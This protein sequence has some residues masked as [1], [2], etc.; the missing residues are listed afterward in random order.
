MVCSI[1][2]SLHN[3]RLDTDIVCS[4]CIKLV[5]NMMLSGFKLVD[6]CD[7]R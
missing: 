5:H 4:P 6:T 3:V 2:V 7:V 1:F